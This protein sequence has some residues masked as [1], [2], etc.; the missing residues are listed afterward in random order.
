MRR[1]AV[2]ALVVALLAGCASSSQTREIELY[3]TPPLPAGETSNYYFTA[4]T[5]Y[6]AHEN[7]EAAIFAR[8]ALDKWELEKAPASQIRLARE[9]LAR[10]LTEQGQRAAALVEYQKLA[11]QYPRVPSYAR[12]I[13]AR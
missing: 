13:Q 9:L 11:A 1:R 5:H 10:S 3:P 8:Y 2:L 12:A 6:R 7:R 4:L